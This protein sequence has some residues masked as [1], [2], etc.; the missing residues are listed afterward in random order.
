VGTLVVDSGLP[1]VLSALRSKAGLSRRQLAI[2]SGV[3]DGTI[4]LIES[5]SSE[6]PHPETLRLLASGL[7]THRLAGRAD[8]EQAEAIY[9]TLMAAAGYLP[10]VGAPVAAAD[11]LP[12][13]IVERVRVLVGSD[14][15]LVR[16]ILA[17]LAH[18]S[19]ADQRSTLRFLADALRWSRE[20]PG[21]PSRR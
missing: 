15:D 2:Q 16:A 20:T 12:P 3:S 1:D 7:A 13:D 19:A 10:S 8:P 21:R 9:A 14:E 5:G 4:K 18:R 6:R 11:E 17:D